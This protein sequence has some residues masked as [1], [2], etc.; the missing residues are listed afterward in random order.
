MDYQNEFKK[1]LLSQPHCKR[2]ITKEFILHVTKLL[3]RYKIIKVKTLKTIASKSN[4][5]DLAIEIS[6][7]TNSYL[8]DVRGKIFILSL[9]PIKKGK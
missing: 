5:K 6:K 2:G 9:N 3:K 8:L 4:I 7:L 1:A